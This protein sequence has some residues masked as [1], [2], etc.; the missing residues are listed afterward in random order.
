MSNLKIGPVDIS[1]GSATFDLGGLKVGSTQFVTNLDGTLVFCSGVSINSTGSQVKQTNATGVTHTLDAPSGQG[2][3][4]NFTTGNVTRWVSGVNGSTE[5]GS[6][7]NTGSDYII[8]RYSDDG[9]Y[10]DS[11]LV[12]NRGTGRVSFTGAEAPTLI[13]STNNTLLATT[14][15]VHNVVGAIDFS[16]YIRKD[17][18]ITSLGSIVYGDTFLAPGGTTGLTPDDGSSFTSGYTPLGTTVAGS[19]IYAAWF[20]PTLSYITYYNMGLSGTWQV[21]GVTGVGGFL[22]KRIA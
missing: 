8:S 15:F 16:P 4:I 21:I 12:I 17:D 19:T 5:Y 3:T 10:L 13:P 9:T 2:R 14:A 7:T 1:A 22:F 11:P 6:G 20:N 18:T